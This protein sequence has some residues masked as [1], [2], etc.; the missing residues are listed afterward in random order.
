MRI[1]IVNIK[2]IKVAALEHL[3]NPETLAESVEAFRAWRKESGCSPVAKKRTFGIAY[4]NPEAR[5]VQKFRFDV[6]GEVDMN[7]AENAYGVV[8]KA[9]PGGR[10]A[11]LRHRGSHDKLGQ[12]VN[13][14]YRTWLPN[15]NE[16]KRD[17][18]LFFEYMN[19]VPEV[20][21]AELITDIYFP[22][23]PLR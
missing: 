23:K 18:A 5:P 2:P 21:E 14:L 6:C 22:L 15:S 16:M 19:V 17:S 13:A 9:I 7:I 11:K 10:Y 1:D 20:L 8:N 4:S 3:D 12:K